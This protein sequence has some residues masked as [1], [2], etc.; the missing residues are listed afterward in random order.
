MHDTTATASLIYERTP[1]WAEGY[2]RATLER[3]ARGPRL[4]LE[5]GHAT[6]VMVPTA[7]V[8]DGILA[9]LRAITALELATGRANIGPVGQRA[10]ELATRPRPA[11]AA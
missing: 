6:Y 2:V 1:G 5:Q 4:V 11:V 8:L 9:N 3:T 10:L 7:H